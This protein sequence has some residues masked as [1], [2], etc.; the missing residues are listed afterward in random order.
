MESF[1]RGVTVYKAR[2]ARRAVL[3][4]AQHDVD[5]PD[6]VDLRP[7]ADDPERDALAASSSPASP[8]TTARW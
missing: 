6:A 1:L 3:A 4:R 7:D 5:L 8:T 2:D